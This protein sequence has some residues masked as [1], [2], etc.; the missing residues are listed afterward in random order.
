[1]PDAQDAW[2]KPAALITGTSA[3]LGRGLA[4]ALLA[5]DWSVYG[6]SRRASDLDGLRSAR[7]DLT[8]HA[9]VGPALEGLVAG[10]PALDLVVLN[11]GILGAIRDIGETPLEDLQRVMETNVWANKTVLDWLLHSDRPV[12]QI[13][14][15]SSGAAVLGNRGWGGY[16]LSKAALNMLTRLYAHEFPDTHLAA[17]APGIIDT[18]MMDRLC[19]ET[20]ATRFPALERLQSARGTDAMPEPMEAAE[21]ILSVL[22]ELRTRPSGSFVDIRE[23]LDPEG[24]AALFG[25]H[26]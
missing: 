4:Q 26:T 23:I 1:M 18:A 10:V 11:A 17:L 6:C 15:I 12:R 3:G 14:L 20:D 7:V 13:L 22:D 16:A 21:R 25:H 19:D 8:R 5:R 9:A 2:R 24:Y